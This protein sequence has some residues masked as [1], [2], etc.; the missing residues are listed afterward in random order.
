MYQKKHLYVSMNEN[1]KQKSGKTT[2]HFKLSFE[3]HILLVILLRIFDMIIKAFI[4]D[5]LFLLT[6]T[7]LT[8]WESHVTNELWFQPIYNVQ[9]STRNLSHSKSS[10]CVS[11][12]GTTLQTRDKILFHGI[13][14]CSS[15]L[16]FRT[17]WSNFRAKSVKRCVWCINYLRRTFFVI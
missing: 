15:K 4:C 17:F 11:N 16:Y 13:T 8:L 14:S 12:Q 3:N 1:V 9:R 2:T 7:W 10:F 6:T 5:L